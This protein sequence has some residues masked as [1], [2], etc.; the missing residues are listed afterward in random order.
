M[1]GLCHRVQLCVTVEL[2]GNG[3][4]IACRKKNVIDPEDKLP[5][6]AEQ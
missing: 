6:P 2:R 1:Q 4:G 5:R 3:M